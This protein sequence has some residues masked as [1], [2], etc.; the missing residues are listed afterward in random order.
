MTPITRVSGKFKETA[1]SLETTAV[2]NFEEKSPEVLAKI[3][4]YEETVREFC[5]KWIHFVM[6]K[7]WYSYAY[8][9]IM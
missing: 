7:D 5:L 4:G 3:E 8:N 1:E 2:K 6:D 9:K